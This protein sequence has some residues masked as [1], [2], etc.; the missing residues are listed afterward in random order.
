MRIA[1]MAAGGLG[2]YYGA[3]LAKDGHDVTFIARGAHLQAIRANGLIVK[4]IHGDVMIKPAK[5]T[6]N[7]AEVGVVDWILF[8]IKTYDNDAAA[9]A[10][11]P[12]IGANTTVVTFQNGVDNHDHIGA[13]IGKEHVIVAPTQVVSNIAA[14]G[15][16]EQKSPFRSSTIGEVY[17]QGLTPRVQTFAD[18]L[19][20]TGIDAIAVAD[21]RIPLWHKLVFIASTS[22]MATLSRTAPYDLIQMPE[23]RATL[24]AAMEEVYAVAKAQGVQVDDGIVE[25]QYQFTMNLKPGAKPSMQLDLEAGKRLE[26]DALSGAVVRLGA[27]KNVPTPVHRTIYVALKME[28][29]RNKSKGKSPK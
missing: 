27:E 8:G 19:K 21:G 17:G 28:D 18:M 3:L 14:P 12:M 9:Q 23:A 24:R 25:R 22:G 1:I 7:P 11:K 5:A 4:S 6:D 2:S 26:I 15:I 29:E 16:I 20:R 13:V 10:I